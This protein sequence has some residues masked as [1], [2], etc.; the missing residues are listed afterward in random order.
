MLGDNMKSGKFVSM[1]L[2][3]VML[4]SAVMP[5][6]AA[7]NEEV[8]ERCRCLANS[9]SRDVAVLEVEGLEKVF[10][11][12]DILKNED[13]KKLKSALNIGEIDLASAK[14]V[15]IMDTKRHC[16]NCSD[17]DENEIWRN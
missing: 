11:I 6:M 12:A 14:A 16:K 17:T 5:A 3:L 8:C 10:L 4:S 13:V 9:E 7:G 1:L 2:V 15:K